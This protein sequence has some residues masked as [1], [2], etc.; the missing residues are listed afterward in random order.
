MPRFLTT[1]ALL[2]L[3]LLAT[4]VTLLAQADGAGG[5]PAEPRAVSVSPSASKEEVQELRNEVAAQ[6]Q[7]IEELKAMVQ[8][9]ANQQGAGDAHVVNAA[10]VQPQPTDGEDRLTLPSSLRRNP[11]SPP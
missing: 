6:Q 4:G 5:A 8:Q 9:L 1:F 3:F 7:T 11:A 10:I 2:V